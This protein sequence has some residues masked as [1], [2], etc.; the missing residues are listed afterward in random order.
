[1]ES[2]H[3]F[4]KAQEQPPS[5]KVI[6][7]LVY[8][9]LR[10]SLEMVGKRIFCIHRINSFSNYQSVFIH[11]MSEIDAHFIAFRVTV[12]LALL[13]LVKVVA[14]AICLRNVFRRTDE[15]F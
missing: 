12:T 5:K 3:F 4:F 10:A 2:S 1:M 8:Y 11:R 7:I 9:I 6:S 14:N 13:Y 15:E